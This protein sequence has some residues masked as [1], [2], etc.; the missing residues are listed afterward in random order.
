MTVRIVSK[1]SVYLVART[2][3]YMPGVTTFLDDQG[4][5]WPTELLGHRH[6]LEETGGPTDAEQLVEMMGR[7]CYMSFGQKAGNKTNRAYLE[8][9]IGLNRDGVAHGS[10]CEHPVFNFIITGAGRGFTH[11]LVRHRVGVAYSQLS[12]RYCDFE[13]EAEEGTWE[14]GFVLPPL[15]SVD[16]DIRQLMASSYELSRETYKKLVG[17]FEEKLKEMLQ[18][19]VWALPVEKT[20][21]RRDIRKA[22]RGA[23]RDILPIGLESIIGFSANART[24]YNMIV[25]RGGPEAEAQIREVF[26]QIC[27]IM[28]QQ[29]PTLFQ[30]AIY[31]QNWDKTRCVILP[32]EKL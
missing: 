7:I 27:D 18:D 3:L 9:L 26:C 22:A 4:L 5:E 28:I 29:M 20:P 16:H 19:E 8:N 31:T 24:L 12:T 10:V 14:P 21:S 15:S 13:R 2:Q 32:R 11:E 25:L 23:A 30:R 1:P 17:M 6:R